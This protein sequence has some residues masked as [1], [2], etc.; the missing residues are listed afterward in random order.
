MKYKLA[1]IAAIAAVA[2][3]QPGQSQA[4]ITGQIQASLIIA[5]GCQVTNGSAVSGNINDFGT[6]DFGTAASTWTNALS[7][8]VSGA[9]ASGTLQVTCDSSI[10]SFSVAIDRGL[11]GNRA[12]KHATL[13]DTV[14][15]D[16]FQD[17]ARSSAYGNNTPVTFP[18][19]GT[20]VDVPIYG[21]IAPN[22]TSVQSGTYTDTLTV[23]LT[24]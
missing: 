4:A 11:H 7:A 15:Y 16:V 2:T 21:A 12:L 13:A 6:L 5:A 1:A 9:G 14:N 23:T 8:Q 22:G 24:F 3:L 20:P 18:S 17:V 10:K 19:S